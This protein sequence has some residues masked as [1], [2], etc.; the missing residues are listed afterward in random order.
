MS[1]LSCPGFHGEE[2]HIQAIIQ[3]LASGP[4]SPECQIQLPFGYQIDTGK[5]A[6][7]V[8]IQ[9]VYF[10]P[11]PITKLLVPVLTAKVNN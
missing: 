5:L 1:Y 6:L 2:R 4:F 10:Y 9:V 7:R 8:Q 3:A 11:F